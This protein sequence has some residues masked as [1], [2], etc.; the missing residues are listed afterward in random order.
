MKKHF[1]LLPFL[2]LASCNSAPQYNY[3]FVETVNTQKNYHIK[4]YL[5]TDYSSDY[6]RLDLTLYKGTKISFCEENLRFILM[7][8]YDANYGLS[9]EE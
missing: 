3:C 1:Y 4:S 2:L 7:E 8:E 5:V 6:V 9:C